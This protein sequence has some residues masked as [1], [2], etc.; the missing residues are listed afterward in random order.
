[1]NPREVAVKPSLSHNASPEAFAAA[2]LRCQGYSPKCSAIGECS[3][4]GDCFRSERQSVVEARREILNAAANIESAEVA[5]LVR[6]A[7]QLLVDRHNSEAGA[8]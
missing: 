2:M 4:E 3:Y 5:K 1:M 6:D 8:I 7:A